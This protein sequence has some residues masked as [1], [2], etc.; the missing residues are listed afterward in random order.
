VLAAGCKKEVETVTVQVDKMYSWMPVKQFW[1]NQT[2]ILGMKPG[3][4]TINIQS[5]GRFEI[6]SPLPASPQHA[7]NGYYTG[8]GASRTWFSD[9]TPF[10]VR[11]SIP[12]NANFYANPGGYRD[13]SSD[14]VLTIYP[15]SYL[16]AA[17]YLHLRSLDPHAV[18]F[19][20]N[21]V[22][23]LHPFGAINRN[24]Y[25]LCSYYT[26][27]PKTN[28]G[29]NL[30]L[31]RLSTGPAPAP[32]AGPLQPKTL[33]SSQL[34]HIP[35]ADPSE[36]NFKEIWA[37]DDYFLVW[38]NYAGLYK[39]KQDG[40]VKQLNGPP[41]FTS[42]PV[43]PTT[44]YKWQGVVYTTQQGSDGNTTIY[45]SAD[46]GETWQRIDGFNRALAFSSFYPVGDSLVAITHGV[47]SNSIYTLRWLTS[48]TLRLRLLK[49]DGLGYTDFADLA[50]L[51]DTVYIGTTNGLFKRPLRQF[52][53]SK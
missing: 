37:I 45:R 35:T 24:D 39:I 34:I 36:R 13:V 5:V 22:G 2:T 49:T 14:T 42:G 52:F 6:L 53:E 16:D 10:D 40:S 1:G 19:E 9:P 20:N 43:S 30:V 48:S 47:I 51:G 32:A 4:N 21:L 15:T 25:L 23:S 50:P 26:D 18:Q 27:N 12:L 3:V 31:T 28:S 44:V 8:L 11:N 46:D 33:L 17:A 7:Q 38:C 41:S 29:F